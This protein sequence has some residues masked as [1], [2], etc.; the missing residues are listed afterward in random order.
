MAGRARTGAADPARERSVVLTPAHRLADDDRLQTRISDLSELGRGVAADGHQP[1]MGHRY[2]LHSTAEH[3]RIPGGH[4]GCLQPA[5]DWMGS[6]S[7][8]SC[9]V[10]YPGVGDGA[11][12]ETVPKK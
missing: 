8:F 11:G 1:A 10:V 2:H 4:A 12:C 9:G 7:A 3:L 6:G 5:G